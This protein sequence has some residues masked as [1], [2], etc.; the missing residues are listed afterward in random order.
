VKRETNTGDA[1][2][3]RK[4]PYCLAYP[5]KP[6]VKEHG[7]EMLNRENQKGILVETLSPWNNP[8]VRIKS[9]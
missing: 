3:V 7:N 6:T 8:S 4:Y 9:D 5:L 2:P 1:R